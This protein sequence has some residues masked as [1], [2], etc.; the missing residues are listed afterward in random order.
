MLSRPELQFRLPVGFRWAQNGKVE[1]DPDRR[2]QQAI[3]LVFEKMTELGSARQVL[4]WFRG[5]KTSLPSL[6]AESPG[7]DVI[8]KLPVYNTIWHMLRNPLYAGAYAFGKT[9]SRT[10][11]VDGRARKRSKP[12]ACSQWQRITRGNQ[13]DDICCSLRFCAHAKS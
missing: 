13:P 12:S 11:V 8:W 3:H 1:L 9:E 2:V 7:H 6:V 4:L 5:E 10:S